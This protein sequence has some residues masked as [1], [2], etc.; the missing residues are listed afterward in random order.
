[1][2]AVSVHALIYTPNLGTYDAVQRLV[3]VDLSHLA[4]IPLGNLSDVRRRDVIVARQHLLCQGDSVLRLGEPPHLSQV[5]AFVHAGVNRLFE[6][7]LIHEQGEFIVKEI[8]SLLP[9]NSHFSPPRTT[10]EPNSTAS[11][12]RLQA[13][14]QSSHAV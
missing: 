6:D 8:H 2:D 9:Y 12:S 5:D 14:G 4:G 3:A 11:A 10:C 7:V 13:C 1:M